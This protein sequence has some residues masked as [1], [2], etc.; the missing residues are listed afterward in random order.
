MDHLDIKIHQI[1][2]C[3]KAVLQIG[4]YLKIKKI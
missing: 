3:K 1:L 2:I 4:I